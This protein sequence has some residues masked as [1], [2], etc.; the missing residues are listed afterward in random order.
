MC[1][2]LEPEMWDLINIVIP[3]V[4]AYWKILAYSMGY[5]IHDVKA[6][7]NDGDNLD[8]QCCKFFENCLTTESGC[9]PKTWEKLLERIKAVGKLSG[10]AKEIENELGVK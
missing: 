4:N 5:S 6:L 8:E 2:L 9:S 10:A 3:K 1:V 7:E